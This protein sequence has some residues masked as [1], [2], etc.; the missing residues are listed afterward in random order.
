MPIRRAHYVLSSHWDREWYLTFQ[1]YRY[2]WVRLLDRVLDGFDSGQLLGPLQTDGQSVVMDDYLEIR[3]E[4]EETVRR[5]AAEGKIVI[6]PWYVLPD[7]FIVSGESLVRN[8]R[9]GRE[10]ARALGGVPSK[11]GFACDLFGQISQMPQIFA[12]FGIPGGFIWRGTNA[13]DTRHVIWRGADGTE[14]PCY[15]FAG[16]GYCEYASR[17][18]GVTNFREQIS[19]DAIASALEGFLNEE[20]ARTEIGPVLLFDGADHNEWDERA[21]KAAVEKMKSMASQWDFV[22]SSLDAYLDEMLAERDKITHVLEGELR[23]TGRRFGPEDNQCTILGVSSSRVWI[24]QAN[25]ECQSLLCQWAEPASAFAAA[26]LGR[27]YPRGFLD[28]AWKWLLQNHP[29][30]SI[31][32]CSIDTVHEDM[33]YRFSQCRQIADRLAGE[34]ALAIAA[35][36]DGVVPEDE[37]RVSVFNPLPRPFD[38]PVDLALRIPTDWPEFQEFFGYEKKPAFRVYDG[39]GNE[40]AYQRVAQRRDRTSYRVYYTR[41]TETL[42]RHEVRICLPMRI[43]ACGYATLVVRRGEINRPTRHPETPALAASDHSMENEFLAVSI[44]STGSLTVRDKRSGQVYSRLLTFEDC[45]DIGD[46]WFHGAAVNDQ[47]FTSTAARSDVALV[48]NGPF[49]AT[50]RIR[51]PMRV[52][53]RFDMRTMTRSEEFTEVVIDSLVTL[54]AGADHLEIETTIHNSADDHRMRVLFPSGAQDA[55]TYFADTPFDVVE[56]PIAL[57]PERHAFREMEIETAPMQSWCAVCGGAGGEA[58]GLAIVTEGLQECAVRDLSERPIALTLFRST[59]RTVLT[60]GEPGGQLRGSM[61]FRY[62]IAP[63]SSGAPDRARLFDLAQLLNGRLRDVQIQRQDQDINRMGSQSLPPEL[64]FFAL[65]GQ[66]VLSS[67]RQVDGGIEARLFNPNAHNVRATLRLNPAAFGGALP[68]Q[69]EFVDLESRPIADA[70]PL[71][72]DTQDGSLAFDIAPKKIVTVRWVM[73][74]KK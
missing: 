50:F 31:C 41:F 9:L 4:R 53:A 12:G 55:R 73:G 44:E 43:P 15:R 22:H 10:R 42:K 70:A 24:K 74:D 68:A 56:R 14:L 23:E 48:A 21:Y 60:D 18:R 8:L 6:G 61:K 34:A 45:A 26:A 5:R 66:A 71:Q 64:S 54:R 30:D 52:P 38:G 28:V 36:V 3:P 27:E 49:L 58:G 46:G 39:E 37:I 13:A 51:T 62:W 17:V 29:H 69:A 35:H 7:E 72:H 16:I 20:A 47:V 11:A 32:G 1:N 33:R 40:L 2:Q 59:G 57:H 67:L 63:I 25:A 65:E 19:Q